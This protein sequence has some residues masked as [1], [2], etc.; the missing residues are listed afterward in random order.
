VNI[1][2]SL[3]QASLT[4]SD[5]LARNNIAKETESIVKML[6]VNIFVE[7]L[8]ENVTH[9]RTMERGIS[10]TPHD[11]ARFALDHQGVHSVKGTF[12]IA[13]LVIIH[14]DITKRMTSH[15]R[16]GWRPRVQPH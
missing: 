16:H 7:F 12:S 14:V 2:K 15:G 1:S 4:L 9:T 11:A 8:D 6:V 10:L 5:N 13:Q 3:G